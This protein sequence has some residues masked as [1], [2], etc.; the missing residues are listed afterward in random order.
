MIVSYGFSQFL[1]YVFEVEES[2]AD[3]PMEPR[4]M[5]DLQNL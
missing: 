4:C 2:I 3:I 1:H 5:G